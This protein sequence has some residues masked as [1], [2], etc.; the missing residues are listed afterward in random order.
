MAME[1]FTNNSTTT[2]FS[3]VASGDPSIVVVSRTG[4][5][6][7]PQFRV[8]VD[9]E[10][11]LVTGGLS[12]TTWTVELGYEGTAA[13]HSSGAAVT[14][15]V[16]AEVMTEIFDGLMVIGNAV[17]GSHT[18]GSILFA[19][20]SGN[21]AQEVAGDFFYDQTGTGPLSTPF[22]LYLGDALNS[23]E[24]AYL[25]LWDLVGSDWKTITVTNG[26]WEVPGAFSTGSITATD[27]TFGSTVSLTSNSNDVGMAISAWSS[28]SSDLLTWS[29][30]SVPL[31]RISK[32]GYFMTRNTSAPANGDLG[33]SE[34][35][36]WLDDTPGATKVKFKAKESSSTVRTDEGALLAVGKS[37][38]RETHPNSDLL[39]LG[40]V[41][42][43]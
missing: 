5:P 42:A 21:L 22:T 11:M 26:T 39:V 10:L 38:C 33:N 14:L 37:G 20:A 23:L 34:L 40:V 18:D 19:D 28:Q 35:A 15:V 1:E 3:N 8:A 30:N 7:G 4:F 41:L 29:V 6:M 24:Q 25:A 43:A 17:V 27:G 16:T 36:I 2:L 31:G 13:A 9:S 32:A 12:G